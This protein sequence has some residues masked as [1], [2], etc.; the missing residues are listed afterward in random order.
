MMNKLKDLNFMQKWA[1]IGLIIGIIVG[2]A[3][4]AIYYS[5]LLVGNI[6]LVHFAG[7]IRPLPAGEG[8]SANYVFSVQNHYL[9]PLSIFI[10]ALISGIIVYKFAPETEGH[11]TDAAILAF[12]NKNGQVRSRVPFVKLLTAALT[13][14]S[15]GSAGREGPTAQISA[16]IGYLLSKHLNISKSDKRTM[17]AV[18]IGAGIGAIFKAPLGGAL[19]SAEVLYRHDME[20]E[21]IFPS[22]I[23]S[24]IGFTIFG[25]FTGY[26]PIFSVGAGILNDIFNPYLLPF[27]VAEGILTGLFARLYVKFFYWVHD[28][29]RR[30]NVRNYLKPAIG[31]IATGAVV[32]AF[33]EVIGVGYGWVQ[34]MVNGNFA[35]FVNTLGIPI[36]LFFL[37]LAIMKMIATSA[38]IASGGSGGVFAPGIFIGSS[39]GIFLALLLNAAF[40]AIIPISSVAAFAI[41]GMLSFFGAA[42]KVPI[43]VTVMVIEMTGSLALLPA[44]MFSIAVALVVS[45]E[46]SIYSS[47]VGNRMDSPA[48]INEYYS[49]LMKKVKVRNILVKI[50]ALNPDDP[51]YK[52]EKLM[53]EHENLSIPVIDSNKK[54]LGVVYMGDVINLGG[55]DKSK[56]VKTI[57]KSIK[58][59]SINDTAE[60]AWYAMVENKAAWCPVIKDRKY[61]GVVMMES[62]FNKYKK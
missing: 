14:G 36:L 13:I 57:I 40:P 48:H 56:G 4:L 35:A 12:H 1:V 18:A 5:I 39:I 33:P 34:L 51:L 23:A 21:A 29:F 2:L 44:A 60:S 42:G 49:P 28:A 59:V 47:Q 22:V 10:G 17:T 7:Y 3:S 27:L 6:F 25:A 61:V 41:I 46:G 16:G 54:L 30:L 58:C 32:L 50:P 62:M 9:L 19:L 24:V 37:V 11:G 31:A 38:S 8:G 45:G 55:R 15:G 52:A 43:A 20:V 26:S 53:K